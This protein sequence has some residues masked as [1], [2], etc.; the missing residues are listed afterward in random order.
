MVEK[1]GIFK[2]EQMYTRQSYPDDEKKEVMFGQS[3][4]LGPA[5]WPLA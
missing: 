4:F 2:T 5:A 1:T 3:F